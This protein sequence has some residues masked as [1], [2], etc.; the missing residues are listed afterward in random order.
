MSRVYKEGCYEM[1]V[2]TQENIVK[3][4]GNPSTTVYQIPFRWLEDTDINIKKQLQDGTVEVLTYLTDYTLTGENDEHGGYATFTVAPLET[5][6]IVIQRIVPYTQETDYEENEIFP[7]DSHEEALDKLTM[8]VQQLAEE[9]SRSLK[10][11]VF[12]TVDPEDVINHVERVYQSVDNIDV[13]SKDLPNVDIVAENI[14]S[15][16]TTAR[17]IDSVVTTAT[18]V[19]DVKTVAQNKASLNVTAANITD[20]KTVAKD[21]ASVNTTAAN[22]EDVK[23]NATNITDI[24]TNAANIGSINQVA[25]IRNNVTLV[26]LNNRKVT[27]VADNMDNV[28]VVANNI[29][30]VVRTGASIDNVNTVA[31]D[32]ANVNTVAGIK[33]DVDQVAMINTQVKKVGDNIGDVLTVANID[34][35]V[36]TVAD[37]AVAVKQ[38]G[39][40]IDV[41]LKSPTYA[42]NAKTWSEGTDTEVRSLGGTHSAKGWAEI[43]AQVAQ[44]NVATETTTGIVRLATADEAEGG[45]LD[46]VAM[47]PLKTEYVVEDYTGKGLQ[48][49]FNGTL[50]GS[51][52]TFN[53]DTQD[54]VLKQGYD[55]EIDLLFPAVGV[56]PDDTQIV[57]KNGSDTVQVVNVRHADASTPITYG[58]MKQICRYDTNVGWRWVFN[59]RYAVTDTGVKVFVMPSYAFQDDRYVTTDTAQNINAGKNFVNNTSSTNI[60]A[61]TNMSICLKNSQAELG[62]D[63]TNADGTVNFKYQGIRTVDKNNEEV[64]YLYSAPDGVGGSFTRLGASTKVDGEYADAF[65][66]IEVDANGKGHLYIPDVDTDSTVSGN[67]AATKEYVDANDVS[68]D[69]ATLK[70][71]DSQ[72]YVSKF[73]VNYSMALEVRSSNQYKPYLYDNNE[74]IYPMGKNSTL[75]I[76]STFTYGG[77][78]GTIKD[79]TTDSK[80]LSFAKIKWSTNNYYGEAVTAASTFV[81]L[82]DGGQ[83]VSIDIESQKVLFYSKTAP[84]ASTAY[85]S[86]IYWYDDTNNRMKKSVDK[87]ATW[88]D[89]YASFPLAS[90]ETSKDSAGNISVTGC[91]FCYSVSFMEAI[92]FCLPFGEIT[93]VF[94]TNSFN[95][96]VQKVPTLFKPLRVL[97]NIGSY[98]TNGHYIGVKLSRK[99]STSNRVYNVGELSNFIGFSNYGFSTNVGTFDLQNGSL[100]TTGVG[101]SSHTDFCPLGK[102][103][104]KNDGSY[105]VWVTGVDCFYPTLNAPMYP[106][107]QETYRFGGSWYRIWSDGFIEQGGI[108]TPAAISVV[109][110]ASFLKAFGSVVLNL[111]LQDRYFYAQGMSNSII[112]PIS[113]TQF[114]YEIGNPSQTNKGMFW[115]AC[116][117]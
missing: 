18:N 64:S 72:S 41:V 2:S 7:A 69:D 96:E 68:L 67:Q 83:L 28:N 25:D 33:D 76:G 92:A 29:T 79:I 19:E 85:G 90:F 109:Y 40:N 101:G 111:T 106:I 51:V 4:Q 8:E 89:C 35:Q 47:T 17:D 70:K 27:T 113:L 5:D 78:T 48:L 34:T 13:V 49:G 84:K 98:T 1:T 103:Y 58:D 9:S 61:H 82:K 46:T 102:F 22:I 59:A 45:V 91:H 14:D 10:I 65:I 42:N 73:P 39:D 77:N 110:T 62:A 99:G 31:G 75:V 94:G 24:N 23:T 71:K 95:R 105:D 87:G 108:V 60:D 97:G 15:V 43:A 6:T 44:V 54:Y 88:T 56:L 26:A 57:I 114:Q 20:V 50:E 74:A 66:D 104:V 116:G 63:T 16:N 30:N 38:I 86:L 107:V 81:L 117:Y 21:I 12:S 36:T 11:S 112:N 115:Y 37:N 32:I 100:L 3:Y 53:P 80:G 52:L 55:Y 93:G